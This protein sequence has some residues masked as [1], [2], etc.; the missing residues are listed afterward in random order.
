MKVLHIS[1]ECYP[2]AKAGGLADVVGAL[3]KYLNNTGVDSAVI[4]PKYHTKW[5]MNQRYVEVFR[6]VMRLD[7]HFIPY[8]IEQEIENKLGYP[9]FV[10]NIPG[11]FDRGGVY[12]DPH[13]G[14]AYGDE[15]E[16]YIC[17][18]QAV[19]YWIMQ[20]PERPQVLHCHDHHTGLIPFLVRYGYEFNSL[21]GTPTIF[22]IHNGQYHGA[23]S[24]KNYNLLP[25][26]DNNYRGLLDWNNTINPLATGVKCCWRLTTVSP[27]YMEELRYSANGLE[28]LIA[29]E[30]SKS[31]GI[32]NGIDNV[33]WDPRGDE[34]I[35]HK[36]NGSVDKYKLANK[37]KLAKRFNINTK[38]PLITF[39]GRLVREKGADIIPDLISR[40]LSAGGKAAFVVLGS[41]EKWVEDQFYAMRDQFPGTFDCAIEY[42]EALAH[43]LYAGSDFLLMP[44]RVEPCGLNQLYALRYGTVPIVRSVG[45]LQDTISDLSEQDA[46]GIRF[47]RFNISAAFTALQ[48]AT[49]FYQHQDS[50]KLLRNR[51][52]DL[53]FSWEKSAS[54]YT[55]IYKDVGLKLIATTEN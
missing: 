55:K 44:S 37:K 54:D 26:F 53:D 21:E 33:V 40:F 17:F 8:S 39:I 12:A 5:M 28:S 4:M 23:F 50:F 24:W 14:R 41:G 47:N 18:Q 27:S 22:T 36:L 32:L 35:P 11:K 15:V 6:G 46:R 3:P 29:Q 42:N 31:C 45:G 25:Y 16:R 48:R 49:E 30:T 2:A 19:L 13:S 10:V 51:N 52:M 38:L 34:L 1:A 43:T 20:L 9:L 7:H